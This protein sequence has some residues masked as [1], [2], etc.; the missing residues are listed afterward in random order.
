MR[1]LFLVPAA[2]F[3]AGCSSIP[4]KPPQGSQA[5]FVILETT[6]LHA[7][8]RSYDY[9]KLA[10][11][12]S[13]GLERTA[14][15]IRQAR[16]EFPNSLLLDNGDTIQG[17][18]LGDYQ[19]LVAPVGCG[20]ALAIYKAMN[21]LGFEG[22]SVGNHEFNWGL[23]FLGQ[24]TASRFGAEGASARAQPCAGPAFPVV[25]ANVVDARSGVPLFE[26]YR[27]LDKRV[28]ATGPDGR[29]VEAT[30]KV[31]IIGFTTPAIMGWDKRW[32]E[33]RVR[34]EG[35]R[36]T[37]QRYIP[38]MRAKGADVIVAISHAGLDGAAYAPA[39]ENGSLYLAQVPGIDA[40]LLGHSHDVFPNA[41][42]KAAGFNLPGVDKVQGRVHGV[43]TVMPGLWGKH[44]GVV[45]LALRHDGERWV[46]DAGSAKVE[47]RSIQRPDRSFVD[48]DPEI[49]ALVKAEHEATIAYV[50]TPIGDTDFRMSAYFA[51]VGDVSAIQIVNQAQ[52]DYVRRHVQANLPQYAQLPVLSMSAPFKTGAAGAADYTDVA[53]GQMALNN[54]ADLYLYPNDLHAVKVDGAT[55][56][57]WLEKSAGRFN[58]IDPARSEPQELVNAAFAGFNFDMLT[59]PDVRYQ[60]DVTQP[61]GQRIKELTWRG[62]P[63]Q[64]GQE[65]IVATNNFR[66]SGGGGFPGLDGSK[67][68]FAS[69][70]NN[71][72]V[73]IAYIKSVQHLSRAANGAAHSWRFA[74]ARTKGP[75]IFRSAPGKLALA[76]EA[77]LDF[78]Q[79]RGD[80]AYE[81]LFDLPIN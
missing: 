20:Q 80:G 34:T 15:L 70:D 27:I 2:A 58:I 73:L 67:T 9:Y 42:G 55:L 69:P 76:R 46:S 65:F 11:D 7:N 52:A 16:K 71:R 44:L 63:V 28:S 23:D 62:R 21:V 33:G 29:P 5:A 57:A 12:A 3:L 8:V 49:A 61:P 25:L 72:A 4:A 10:P 59:D 30:L 18:A 51:D 54:A 43:P 53:P 41:A 17:T 26:P 19:A 40:L 38:E 68:I 56:K 22:G 39:M 31:G 78:V 60:I 13:L 45:Q 24:V 32:L 1:L 37:A 47:T 50:K 48:P 64:P 81:I 77:G 36:E 35:W 75:V 74:P 79:E 6:D 66:A 14:T